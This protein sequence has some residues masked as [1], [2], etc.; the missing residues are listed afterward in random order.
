LIH[1]TGLPSALPVLVN[2]ILIHIV[3]VGLPS[4]LF[5]RAA[6]PVPASPEVP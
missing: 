4:A 5:A 2:G 1:G 6:A 3:G